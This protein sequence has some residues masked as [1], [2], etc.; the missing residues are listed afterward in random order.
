MHQAI[1]NKH[2]EVVKL[3]FETY[4]VKEK[5]D[6]GAKYFA[7]CTEKYHIKGLVALIEAGVFIDNQDITTGQ[8]ALHS[9]IME[10]RNDVAS[11]LIERG[12]DL[13]K[14]DNLGWSALHHC[15]GSGNLEVLKL[16]VNDTIDVNA[17]DLNKN[18]A[19][20]LASSK[21]Y[22]DIVK[23]LID[24]GAV[25]DFGCESGNFFE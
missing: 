13:R 12:A 21:G 18:T 24:N 16:V 3:L 6:L 5:I 8:T 25:M 15:V 23:F 1:E 2:P 7:F 10:G 11:V 17:C 9:A 19:L 14:C 4:S 20:Q 22:L